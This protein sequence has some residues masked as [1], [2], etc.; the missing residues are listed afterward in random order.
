MLEQEE[1]THCEV[2]SSLEQKVA[3]QHQEINYIMDL[4]L[5]NYW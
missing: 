3:W 1:I 5:W 4:S 2:L